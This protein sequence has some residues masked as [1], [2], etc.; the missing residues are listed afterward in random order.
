LFQWTDRVQKVEGERKK[1]GRENGGG[2]RQGR[3]EIIII[4]IQ[5]LYSALKVL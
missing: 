5:Y 1:H 3:T 4:I 2:I